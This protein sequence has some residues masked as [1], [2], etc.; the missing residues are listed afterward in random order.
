M[1]NKRKKGRK[2]NDKKCI[3]ANHWDCKRERERERVILTKLCFINHA[4]KS[5][6]ISVLKNNKYIKN[7][8]IGYV[9]RCKSYV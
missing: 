7:R 5:N 2:Q 6:G 1:G 9:D 4:K 3:K 8:E